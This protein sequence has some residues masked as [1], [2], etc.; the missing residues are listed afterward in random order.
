MDLQTTTN[1][2]QK[3]SR[4][5]KETNGARYEVKRR[6]TCPTRAELGS[7]EKAIAYGQ[8]RGLSAVA[9]NR[10]I[11]LVTNVIDD[12]DWRDHRRLP[13]S[14]RVPRSLENTGTPERYW[15]VSDVG[16]TI[17]GDAWTDECTATGLT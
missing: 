16:E 5:Q 14:E 10:I 3:R 13:S 7:I 11:S 4:V 12:I 1:W 6:R 15:D 8:S 9:T 2:R 17:C